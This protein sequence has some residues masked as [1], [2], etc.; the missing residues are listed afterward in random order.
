MAKFIFKLEVVLRQRKHVEAE[1]QRDVAARHKL[2][3]E[4]MEELRDLQDR[5]RGATEEL[6][7]NPLVGEL[8][9]SF[10]TAHRR[11]MLASHRQAM[12]IAQ[13]IATAQKAADE[14]Q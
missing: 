4:C 8:D 2:L 7:Q 10:L 1:K 14:A 9:M 11:Y 5:V 12:A 3:A 6:R 13:K